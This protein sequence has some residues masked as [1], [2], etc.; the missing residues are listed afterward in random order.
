MLGKS[1][2]SLLRLLY[3]RGLPLLQA[4]TRHAALGTVE[5]DETALT[6]LHDVLWSG[7]KDGPRSVL[8]LR[9]NA[10]RVVGLQIQAGSLLVSASCPH[11]LLTKALSPPLVIHRARRQTARRHSLPFKPT[12]PLRCGSGRLA[13]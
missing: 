9:T 4:L 11:S 12:V 6:R 5:L 1:A 2:L 3:W 10:S 13:S 8:A 7:R